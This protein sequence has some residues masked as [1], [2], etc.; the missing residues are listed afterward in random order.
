MPVE[1]NLHVLDL[2]FDLSA[3]PIFNSYGGLAQRR[4][5]EAMC[6]VTIFRPV[7]RDSVELRVR[8]KTDLPWEHEMQDDL[9]F[10]DEIGVAPIQLA[11]AD[12]TFPS[13]WG[14]PGKQP[15]SLR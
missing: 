6:H 4:Q 9:A 3:G 7:L 14:L 8:M 11:T 5:I 10:F 13:R 1:D 2:A 12:G 15:L